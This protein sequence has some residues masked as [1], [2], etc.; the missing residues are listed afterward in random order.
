MC[1]VPGTVLGT[2]LHE[3]MNEFSVSMSIVPL[4]CELLGGTLKMLN[5]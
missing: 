2:K 3:W 5:E 4:D 1:Y